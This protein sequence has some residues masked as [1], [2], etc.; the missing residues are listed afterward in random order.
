MW[1]GPIAYIGTN[2]ILIIAGIVVLLFGGAKLPQLARGMGQGIREFKQSVGGDD[3]A[4]TA[5]KAPAAGET[6][7]AS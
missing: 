2:E 4:V 5:V 7:A 1:T 3:E 6:S